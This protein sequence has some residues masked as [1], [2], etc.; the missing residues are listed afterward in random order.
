MLF[1]SKCLVQMPTRPPSVDTW[2]SSG[3]PI[4]DPKFVK[5]LRLR[6]SL[7]LENRVQS[8]EGQRAFSTGELLMANRMTKQCVHIPCLCNVANGQEYCG[9]SCRDAGSDDV[10]IACQC[11]HPAYPADS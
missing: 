7:P 9:Q 4:T 2:L 10:E 11:D 1:V 6:R 3:L 8:V 5:T